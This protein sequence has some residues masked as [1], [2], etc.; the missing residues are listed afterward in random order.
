MAYNSEDDVES[1]DESIDDSQPDME[2]SQHLT[3]VKTEA[4]VNG[5]LD[6]AIHLVFLKQILHLAGTAVPS[7]CSEKEC[8][9]EVSIVTEVISSA[10]YLKWV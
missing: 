1:D 8:H 6:D 10:L 5:L 2:L 9:Q 3:S 7:I 4:D